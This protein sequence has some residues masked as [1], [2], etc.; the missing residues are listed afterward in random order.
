MQYIRR[1]IH[2]VVAAVADDAGLPVTCAV[3]IMDSDGHSLFFLTARGK[4]FYKR[5]KQRGYMAL[6]GI[7]GTETLSCAAI[8]LRGKVRELGAEKIPE[9]FEKN[10]YMK[11]IYPTKESRRTLTVFQLYEGN[12]EWFDLSQKPV[13]RFSF[14]FGQA[15][16]KQEEYY[17]TDA[18]TGCRRCEAV[19]PQRCIDVSSTPAVI[20]QIHCL[21]CGSCRMICPQNAVRWGRKENDPEGKAT[22]FNPGAS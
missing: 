13:E 17:I 22:L 19:C 9:M 14:A 1:N 3:D 12:G 21:H 15:A 20:R 6:T 4:G 18:C 10:P 2:T 16:S 11:E 5:L 7:K 8:S